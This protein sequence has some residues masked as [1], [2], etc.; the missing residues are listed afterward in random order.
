MASGERML[1]DQQET[2]G[3]PGAPTTGVPPTPGQPVTVKA[4]LR[5]EYVA[6]GGSAAI[7][8]LENFA[9]S[10]P[11]AIDDV[12]A[13]FGD[14]LY[15][16]MRFDP[17]CDAALTTLKSGVLESGLSLLP[18]VDQKDEDGYDLAVEIQ[19]AA[20]QMLDELDTPFEDVCW[21]L[22]DAIAY[23]N[24]VAEQKYATRTLKGKSNLALVA[25]K[26]K[27][28]RAIAFAVDVYGNVIG[29]LGMVPGVAVP[30]QSGLLMAQPDR[31]P[32]LLPRH[33]FVVWTHRPKKGDPRGTSALRA[34]YS[35]WWM[36]Q[37]I[38]PEYLKYLTQFAGP[39]LIG[40]TPENATMLVPTDALGNPTGETATSPEQALKNELLTFKNGTVIAVPHGTVID[41]LKV[42]GDGRAF[43]EAIALLNQQ[44]TKAILTQNLATEEGE[45]G[46]THAASSVHQEALDMVV[47]QEKRS[48]QRMV[49]QD[50]LRPWIGY[51]WGDKAKALCPKASLGTTTK[52][53]FAAL[54]TPIAVLFQSGYFHPSQLP[55]MDRALDLPVRDADEAP[56]LPQQPPA[57]PPLPAAGTPPRQGGKPPAPTPLPVVKPAKAGAA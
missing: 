4:D 22:A 3:T 54:A 10:L 31:V 15:E 27:P 48:F 9:R 52:H 18:A 36:K 44:I 49:V 12:T 53:D 16:K 42:D 33:K 46:S 50:I 32:N 30:V 38:L 35:T 11:W 45:N 7:T 39:S 55:A 17:Q 6:A 29:L 40:V 25:L 14:D 57:Q 23:G 41:A 1:T 34:A 37:Q 13:D 47:R 21:D 19:E 51:N 8:W 20:T 2:L 5:R 56:P 43:L 28:R 26:V 24:M